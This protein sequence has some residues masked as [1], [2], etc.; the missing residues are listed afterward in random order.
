MY[1]LYELIEHLGEKVTTLGIDPRFKEN[2]AF[3]SVIHE[4][5]ILLSSMNLEK[6]E[7]EKLHVTV[8]EGRISFSCTTNQGRK[9][10]CEISCSSPETFKCI[11]TEERSPKEQPYRE[12]Y[13]IEKKATIDEYGFITLTTCGANI[14]SIEGDQN[15]CS[16][17]SRAERSYYTSYGIMRDKEIKTFKPGELFSSFDGASINDMLYTPRQGFDGQFFSDKYQSRTLLTRERL[18]VARVVID[19]KKRQTMYVASLPLNQEF[20]LRDMYINGGY[21]YPREVV[22][23]P[24]SKEEIEEKIARERDPK[25]MEGLRAYVK[26]RETYSYDSKND[27]YFKYEG[28]DNTQGISR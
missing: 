4:I 14:H 1:N 15:H 10:T 28:F 5:D 6:E 3:S 19:D 20:G 24:L 21:S 22:I 27:P 25:V 17:T 7:K 8:K 11:F 26:D 9:Y 13:V 23:P 2:P 12:K 16:I 18:D